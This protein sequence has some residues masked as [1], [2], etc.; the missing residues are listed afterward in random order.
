MLSHDINFAAGYCVLVTSRND[1]RTA[2]T[3]RKLEMETVRASKKHT[4]KSFYIFKL[5]RQLPG[6]LIYQ[7]MGNV[8][9]DDA[10]T[11]K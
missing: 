7:F 6:Y 5:V 8:K 9:V 10:T 11:W 4:L 2:L 3:K 1:E